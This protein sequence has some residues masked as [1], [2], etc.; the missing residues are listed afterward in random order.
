MV[1]EV[2]P[3]AFRSV[4][5]LA[6]L[7]ALA[8]SLTACRLERPDPAS[9]A[10]A[11]LHKHPADFTDQLASL[12]ALA[13]REASALSRDSADSPVNGKA[14]RV[15]LSES[16]YAYSVRL[17]P[18]M[19]AAASDSARIALLSAFLYDSLGIDPVRGRPTLASSVPSLV[20]SGRKGSCVGMT[21]L[22]LALGRSL[23]LRL[24]PVF[25]PG[26]VFVRWRSDSGAINIETMKRGIARSDSF[27]RERFLLAKRPWYSLADGKPE[28]ALAALV[29]NLGN[30]HR[31][32]GDVKSAREEYRLAEEAM[33]G[34]PEAVGNQG[35]CR[36]LAGDTAEARREFAAALAGDSLAEPA[37]HNLEILDRASNLEGI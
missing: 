36:M 37:W 13:A 9:Q 20:L 11:I 19:A 26:H 28:Q 33:P 14:P 27:Y 30:A 2:S 23:H 18:A 7:A 17:K 1:L 5:A 10:A 35:V 25:L 15:S 6:T 32:A 12:D 31:L 21:L 24:A 8:C 29:F 22:Y 16:L 34:Y 3:R 4:P